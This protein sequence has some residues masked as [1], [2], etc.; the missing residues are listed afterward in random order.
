MKI[1]GDLNF[2]RETDKEVYT[3]FGCLDLY[4]LIILL[5]FM[6]RIES[7]LG[8]EDNKSRTLMEDQQ[9]KSNVRT[10]IP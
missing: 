7:L 5:W 10:P 9:S 1:E 4:Y 2:C 3:A 6:Q 8:P